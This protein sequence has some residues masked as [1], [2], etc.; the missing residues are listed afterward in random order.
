MSKNSQNS[1][2]KRKEDPWDSFASAFQG[3]WNDHR[4]T[5]YVKVAECLVKNYCIMVCKV[6]LKVFDAYLDDYKENMGAFSEEQSERF[7]QG[8]IDFECCYH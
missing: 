7:H 6:S 8:I 5:N 2:V 3:F 4:A 1:L